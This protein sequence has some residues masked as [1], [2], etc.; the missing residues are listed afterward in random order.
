MKCVACGGEVP[1]AAQFCPGCGIP[2]AVPAATPAPMPQ[3][4]GQAWTILAGTAPALPLL[5]VGVGAA[6][7]LQAVIGLAI[8]TGEEPLS[9]GFLHGSIW[10]DLA[11]VLEVGAF[12][13]SAAARA[14]R[15]DPRWAPATSRLVAA[16]GA[17]LALVFA[18]VALAVVYGDLAAE[19]LADGAVWALFS[20]AWG[21]FVLGLLTWSRPLLPRE[22]VGAAVVFGSLAALFS[23]IGLA[24]GLGNDFEDGVRGEMWLNLASVAALLAAAG[25]LGRRRPS[26]ASG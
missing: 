12:A 16:A 18:I 24:T 25:L 7:L 19:D 2:A 6:G 21:M 15:A 9:M 13:L 5:G 23:V 17:V 4:F 11:L 10:L 8:A 22:G 3:V 1:T 20:G 26:R 14:R